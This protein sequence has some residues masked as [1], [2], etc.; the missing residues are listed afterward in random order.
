MNGEPTDLSRKTST[1]SK[2]EVLQELDALMTG[3]WLSDLANFCAFFYT[4]FS[5]INWLGFYLSDG[6][7]LRLGPFMGKPACVEINFDRGVCGSSFVQK[8]ALRVDDVHLF[9]GHISCDPQSRS[10][11][12]LPFEIGG[13]LLGVLDVDSPETSRFHESDEHLLS[14]GLSILAKHNSGYRGLLGEPPSMSVG[15]AEL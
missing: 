11:M 10:E 5:S 4:H 6:N 14:A 1:N 9:A 3:F 15:S 8:K 12:V 13:H 2:T 7:K